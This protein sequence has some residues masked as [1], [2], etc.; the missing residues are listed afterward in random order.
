MASA[1]CKKAYAVIRKYEGGKVNDRD[2]PGGRTN[3]GITQR[4]YDAYRRLKGQA[5]QSVYEATEK[6]IETIYKVQYWA[7]ARCDDMPAGID[8][9]VFDTS[10]NSGIKR[11]AKLLQASLIARQKASGSGS[12]ARLRVDGQIGMATLAALDNDLDNDLLI[13]EF[14]RR[15]QGFYRGLKTFRKF[16][17]GWTKRNANCVKI[18]QAWATGSVGPDPIPAYS[19]TQG[20]APKAYDETI[21]TGNA[22]PAAGGV[23]AGTGVTGDA[24]TSSYIGHLQEQAALAQEAVSP[25]VD[26]LEALRWVFIALAI[27]GTL[28]TIW[29]GYATWRN[30]RIRDGEVVSSYDPDA[31][32]DDAAVHGA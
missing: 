8:L 20:G 30:R 21:K 12:N 13:A 19:Q 10:V 24:A 3:A 11:A 28:L 15:R 5:Q 7:A 16:G 25:L 18:A 22:T 32:V 2:D 29:A 17:K 4:V 1:N 26:Y 6:E 31:D 14:G 9:C 23:V 27:A